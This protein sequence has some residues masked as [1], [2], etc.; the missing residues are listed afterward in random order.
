MSSSEKYGTECS[1]RKRKLLVDLPNEVIVE[2]IEALMGMRQRHDHWD[3][4]FYAKE[5]ISSLRLTCKLLADLGAR[6]P[7]EQVCF[8]CFLVELSLIYGIF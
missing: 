1:L 2:I 4:P 7:A 6:Y 8:I 5:H 3:T